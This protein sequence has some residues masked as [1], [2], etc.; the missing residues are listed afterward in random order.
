M[1]RYSNS[2]CTVQ[3]QIEYIKE[4]DVGHYAQIR[5]DIKNGIGSNPDAVPVLLRIYPI[6]RQI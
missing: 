2:I 4:V 1:I 5:K 6:N 3:E